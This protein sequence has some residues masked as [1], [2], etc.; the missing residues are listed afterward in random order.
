MSK[1]T[2]QINRSEIFYQAALHSSSIFETVLAPVIFDEKSLRLAR[3]FAKEERLAALIAYDHRKVDRDTI[4][5]VAFMARKIAEEGFPTILVSTNDQLDIAQ[6]FCAQNPI[7]SEQIQRLHHH[8]R[9]LSSKP[10]RFPKD[11][12][13]LLLAQ[14][15]Y[16]DRGTAVTLLTELLASLGENN[17]AWTARVAAV[18][19]YFSVC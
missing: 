7:G 9:E 14:V 11:N 10:P 5:E 8:R 6:I 19:A 13:E 4:Y 15:T 16:P 2:E 12:L 1:R 3:L 18:L 17:S